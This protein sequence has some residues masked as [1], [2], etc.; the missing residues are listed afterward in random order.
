MARALVWNASIPC[1]NLHQADEEKKD[2]LFVRKDIELFGEQDTKREVVERDIVE[3]EREE[4]ELDDKDEVKKEVEEKEAFER[5]VEEREMTKVE[6]WEFVNNTVLP[7]SQCSGTKCI[8][9]F[10]ILD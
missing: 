1:Y 4:N 6:L 9:I 5:V 7:A 8:H 10:K 2:E 3:R